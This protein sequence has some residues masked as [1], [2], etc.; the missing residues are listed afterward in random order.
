MTRHSRS[1][2]VAQI[3]K[4][5]NTNWSVISRSLELKVK[6][7]IILFV[8][9]KLLLLSDII[10]SC[11]VQ[12]RLWYPVGTVNPCQHGKTDVKAVDALLLLFYFCYYMRKLRLI[13][14]VARVVTGNVFLQLVTCPIPICIH[15]FSIT[16]FCHIFTLLL[17]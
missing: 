9:L 17:Q 13:F 3:A 8:K 16:L 2:A 10:K 12:C 4:W 14:N 5:L 6:S 7:I 11:L 15:F 1:L